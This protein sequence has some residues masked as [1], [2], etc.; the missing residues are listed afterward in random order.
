MII[1]KERIKVMMMLFI[2][3]LGLVI[4][5]AGKSKAQERIDAWYGEPF[6]QLIFSMQANKEKFK[7]KNYGDGKR[8]VT[9]T[10]Y[11]GVPCEYVSL[12]EGLTISY[13]I[14][15]YKRK[16]YAEREES[17]KRNWKH[18]G[19]FYLLRNTVVAMFDA[20]KNRIGFARI[21]DISKH[22]FKLY[23][24]GLEGTKIFSK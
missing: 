22:G 4:W 9:M 13:R 23:G 15:H 18:V 21:E 12:D 8:S 11:R 5:A 24:N 19:D 6:E 7:Y 3:S 2:M 1:S 20:R 14:D 10:D 17:I 16:Q